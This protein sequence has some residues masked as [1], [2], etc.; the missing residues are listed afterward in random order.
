MVE[1]DRI[2]FV[3]NL[4]SEKFDIILGSH[5]NYCI[6]NRKIQVHFLGNLEKKKKIPCFSCC[7]SCG[8]FVLGRQQPIFLMV[9][10]QESSYEIKKMIG[11]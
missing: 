6:K 1:E 8:L 3:I 9:E 7:L 11:N 2:K 10:E 5:K 4:K